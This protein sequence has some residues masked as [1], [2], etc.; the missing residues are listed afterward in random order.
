MVSGGK[1]STE[2]RGNGVRFHRP[3]WK[4]FPRYNSLSIWALK[5]LSGVFH[6]SKVFHSTPRV[7]SNL[8]PSK[9]G[10]LSNPVEVERPL[11]VL[12]KGP[13]R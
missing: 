5:P 1:V 6:H 9:Q 2:G 13:R 11:E 12:T 3:G 8:I 4:D 10:L 7:S